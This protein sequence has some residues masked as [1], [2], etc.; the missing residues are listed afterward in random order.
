M[1]K[2]VQVSEKQ[3]EQAYQNWV[4]FHY[5]WDCEEAINRFFAWVDPHKDDRSA[6]DP[7]SDRK[8]LK[9]L[10]RTAGRI[11]MLLDNPTAYLKAWYIQNPWK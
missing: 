11:K 8:V 3:M 5:G 7:W 6:L 9:V 10:P 4:D 2:R 1:S